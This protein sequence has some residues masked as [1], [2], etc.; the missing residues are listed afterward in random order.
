MN[1]LVY[2]GLFLKASLLSSGGTGNLPSLR[3][4]FLARHWA[5]DHEFVQSLTIG[6]IAP[7]PNGLWVVSF[8]YLTAGVSGSILALVGTVIPPLLVIGV[9]KAYRKVN[10]H[11]GVEG[12]VQ[13]LSLAICGVFL[14]V[15]SMLF[16]TDGITF[17][18]CG[19][20]AGAVILGASQRVPIPAI[21]A[22]AA[23]AGIATSH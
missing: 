19:L 20:C 4:D 13:G 17:E 8:G 7:G 21:L 18:S 9:E 15:L 2:F 3:D 11:P 23:I 14:M 5:T 22:L 6:Q 10:H 1:N 12:F 16:R